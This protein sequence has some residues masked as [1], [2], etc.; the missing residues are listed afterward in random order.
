[1]YNK[2]MIPVSSTEQPV[3]TFT[4]TSKPQV[5][6]MSAAK[7]GWLH[8]QQKPGAEFDLRI[9]DIRGNVKFERL[10]IKN[11]A[12]TYGELANIPGM[13]GEELLVEVSNLKGSDKVVVL[14]N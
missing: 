14:L 2:A 8:T 13:I 10:G 12:E 3:L 9:K 5:H 7:V 11:T 6:R 4:P 1:M